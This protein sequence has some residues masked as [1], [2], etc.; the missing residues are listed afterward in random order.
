MLPHPTSV[1]SMYSGIHRGHFNCCFATTTG[2]FAAQDD[3]GIPLVHKTNPDITHRLPAYGPMN[4]WSCTGAGNPAGHITEVM[5]P[6]NH[7]T[8]LT[9]SG[10]VALKHLDAGLNDLAS[11]DLSGLPAL[12]TLV[13][14]KNRLASLDVRGLSRL[15]T[16][17]CYG[18]LLTALDLTGLDKL[19]ILH[20][21]MNQLV[22]LRL[23]GCKSLHTLYAYWNRITNLDLSSLPAPRER[24]LRGNPLDPRP[25][26]MVLG[27]LG[28]TSSPCFQEVA[29]DPSPGKRRTQEWLEQGSGMSRGRP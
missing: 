1:I 25:A 23:G 16:L 17:S 20:C 3:A 14:T 21:S 29:G 7:L 19:E 6:G 9:V 4:I 2:F 24:N 11:L 10:Q 18:N 22:S 27:G 5:C 15:K 28:E 26:I 13:L 12:E 8:A